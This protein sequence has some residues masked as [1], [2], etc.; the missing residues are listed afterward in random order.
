LLNCKTIRVSRGRPIVM[1]LFY[2][3]L[4]G[5]GIASPFTEPSG[6]PG[7]KTERRSATENSGHVS[8]VHGADLTIPRFSFGDCH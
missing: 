8:D 6:M 7:M 4:P 2:C 1:G 5:G 3:S